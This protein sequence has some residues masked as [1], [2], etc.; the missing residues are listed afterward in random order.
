MYNLISFLNRFL[1]FFFP[2]PVKITIYSVPLCLAFI[3][4]PEQILISNTEVNIF[5]NFRILIKAENWKLWYKKRLTTYC[6]WTR[7]TRDSIEKIWN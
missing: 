3:L 4:L 6:E 1:D 7:V 2:V 5:S